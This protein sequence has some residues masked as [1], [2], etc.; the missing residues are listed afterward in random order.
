MDTCICMAEFFHCS[1]ETNTTL[2]TGYSLVQ[3]KKFKVKKKRKNLPCKGRDTSWIS[4]RRKI[5]HASGQVNLCATTTDPVCALKPK[6]CQLLSLHPATREASTVRSPHTTIREQLPLSSTR[7]S[8]C[9]ATQ[10]QR[11]QK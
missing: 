4:G 2:L 5:P 9:T 11:S 1:P 8:Q 10:A 3:N 7:E 6:S